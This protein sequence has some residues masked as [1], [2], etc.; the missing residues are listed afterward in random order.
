M[1]RSKFHYGVIVDHKREGT[2][3][4]NI[5]IVTNGTPVG[6]RFKRATTGREC[7]SESNL[8]PNE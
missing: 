3:A 8:V 2:S 4:A 5:Y 6:E 7:T 1:A